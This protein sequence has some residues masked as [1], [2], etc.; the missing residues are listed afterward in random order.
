MSNQFFKGKSKY[1]WFLIERRPFLN[2]VNMNFLGCVGT[3]S[4]NV[5]ILTLGPDMNP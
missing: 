3:F 1:V 2:M 4:Q 5:R